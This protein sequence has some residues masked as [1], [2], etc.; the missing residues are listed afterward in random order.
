MSLANALTPTDVPGSSSIGAPVSAHWTATTPTVPMAVRIQPT[1]AMDKR[2]GTDR[3]VTATATNAAPIRATRP[4]YR[5]QRA[6]IPGGEPDW[7]VPTPSWSAGLDGGA[8]PMPNT[9]EPADT[10]PS[11]ADTVRQE[12]V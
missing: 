12:T 3:L 11:T 6:R 4:R 8:T 7:L 10:W 2:S 5:I 9:N 1:A